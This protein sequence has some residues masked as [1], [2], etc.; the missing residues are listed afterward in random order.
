M[1]NAW[2][3][4]AV[5][6]PFTLQLLLVRPKVPDQVDIGR[7]VVYELGIILQKVD[8]AIRRVY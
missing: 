1:L 5:Q 8:E 4:V 6:G 2:I 3:L 7:K